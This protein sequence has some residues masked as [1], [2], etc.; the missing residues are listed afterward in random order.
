MPKKKEAAPT[1]EIIFP[2]HYY[3]CG[4]DLSLRR[5]G[6]CLLE[7]DNKNGKA[8]MVNVRLYSVDNKG[9][10]NKTHG[11]ILREIL[12]RFNKFLSCS[13][14]SDESSDGSDEKFFFVREKMILN[15]KVPSERDVAK[16][17]GIMDYYLESQEWFEIY[18]VTV[19]RLV[20][21]SGKAEK[22]DV[23]DALLKYVGEQ[24]Y[25]ND[26]E[27]DATAVAVAWLIQN[28]QI[29]EAQE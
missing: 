20:A 24:K 29:Q 28:H 26:D 9:K 10:K 3:V 7:V 16:V 19:K 25:L 22:K 12:Y 14:I 27:S 11:E 18:P 15:K 13:K 1:E 6:F 2:Q 17:V 23:A 5:P 4:A 21:G 8:N